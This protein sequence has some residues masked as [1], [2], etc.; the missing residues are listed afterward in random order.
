M[1]DPILYELAE[2]IAAIAEATSATQD[3]LGIICRHIASAHPTISSELSALLKGLQEGI[4]IEATPAFVAVA[5]RLQ[6]ELSG[7]IDVP[8]HGLMKRIQKPTSP[9]ELRACLRLIRGGKE[10]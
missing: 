10:P 2:A 4:D 7:D 6:R 3:M 8:F 5:T 9:E 1:N